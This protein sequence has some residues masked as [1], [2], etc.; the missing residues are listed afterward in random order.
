[1]PSS[2]LHKLSYCK[3]FKIFELPPST[4]IQGNTLIRQ[5]QNFLKKLEKVKGIPQESLLV[6]LDVKSIYTT[7]PNNEGTKAVKESYEKYKEKMVSTKLL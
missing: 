6:T 2:R 1:M 3:Y 7:I 5:R 4:Y